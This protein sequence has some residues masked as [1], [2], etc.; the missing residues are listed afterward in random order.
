MMMMDTR[1][2][3]KKKKKKKKEKKKYL[4]LYVSAV[5]FPSIWVTN[6]FCPASV[7]V[8]FRFEP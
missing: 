7:F 8:S 4:L 1:E 5:R 6:V 2:R 3:K